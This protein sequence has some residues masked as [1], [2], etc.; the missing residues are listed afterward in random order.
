VR[1]VD[2]VKQG[3]PVAPGNELL[4][5]GEKEAH[6]RAERLAQGVPLPDETWNLILET[7]RL[8]GLDT[9]KVQRA[10]AGHR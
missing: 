3:K 5:P 6:T 1:Y 8:A 4:L 9:D 10:A 7:A 2:F